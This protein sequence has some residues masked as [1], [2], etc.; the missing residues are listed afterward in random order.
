MRTRLFLSLALAALAAAH[1]P[2]GVGQEAAGQGQSAQTEQ[3]AAWSR[4]TYRGE[5]FSAELPGMPTVFNTYRVRAGRSVSDAE[6]VRVFS[7][8]SDGVVYFVVAY[9]GPRKS[10]PLDTFAANLRGAWGLAPKGDLTLAGFE[11]RAYDVVG[12]QRGRITYDLY[13]EGR[14][15][16]AKRHAYLALAFSDEAGRP[17]VARFL[18]AFTLDESPAGERIAEE[19]PVPRFVPP[20]TQPG[21]QPG[22]VIGP[23]RG[24]DTGGG[25]EN[26]KLAGPEGAMT[27]PLTEKRFVRKARIVYKPEPPYTEEARRK[28]VN[29]TVRL[30]AVLSSNGRVTAIEP[31]SWL[32]NG[33]TESAIRVARHMVFFP[34]VKDGRPVSQYVTLEYNFNVY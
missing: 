16:R 8:Y 23:G 22:A 33:L 13:G 25:E 31:L 4:Y 1:A 12:A 20:Q 18:D 24:G 26:L 10:E 11:G 2:R 5:E 9:D 7:L 30:R 29:G 21:T 34:A 17:E 28:R 14:V 27:G 15:F 3:S 32:P 19:E 6:G